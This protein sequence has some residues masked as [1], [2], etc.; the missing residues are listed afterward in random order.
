MCWKNKKYKSQKNSSVFLG[1]NKKSVNAE[2]WAISN[3]LDIAR[4]TT[5]NCHQTPITVFSDSR[6]ALTTLCQLSS[7]TNTLYLKNLVN[8]KTS[9]QKS[10]GHSVVIWQIPNHV[11][12]VGHD[13]ADQSAK[14]KAQRQGNPVE[15]QSSLTHIKKKLIESH[16]QE[17]TR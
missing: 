17:L 12:L 5:L 9:D 15:Q 4:K 3:G 2:L 13:K 10:K 8:Q 6:K 11:R 16:S 7:Y 1:K 14:D